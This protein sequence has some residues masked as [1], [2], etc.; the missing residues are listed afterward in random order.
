MRSGDGSSDVFSSDLRLAVLASEVGSGAG[1]IDT[2]NR[3]TVDGSLIESR[4]WAFGHHFLGTQQ[5]LRLRDGDPNRTGCHCRRGNS[6]LLDR[7]D[8]TAGKR[9]SERVEIWCRSSIK[10]Q[11]TKH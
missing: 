4:Q 10:T 6:G 1:D 5:S 3:V 8:V 2:T 11:T 9:G 7:N